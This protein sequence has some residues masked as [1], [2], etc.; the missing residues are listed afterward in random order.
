MYLCFTPLQG[1]IITN[2]IHI[3]SVLLIEEDCEKV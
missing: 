1:G 2:K 3:I